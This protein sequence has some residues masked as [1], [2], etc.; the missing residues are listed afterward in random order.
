MLSQ[1]DL[2]AESQDDYSLH[3][4]G[5]L[6][7]AVLAAINELVNEVINHTYIFLQY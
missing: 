4:V 7:A 2:G 5:A 6:K 3:F 1:L